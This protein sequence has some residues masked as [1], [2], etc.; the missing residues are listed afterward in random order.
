[1]HGRLLKMR[2]K[3]GHA[4]RSV[5]M[6]DGDICRKVRMIKFWEKSTSGKRYIRN[7][8]PTHL[9]AEANIKCLEH[10]TSPYCSFNSMLIDTTRLVR[11]TS[12]NKGQKCQQVRSWI[13]QLQLALVR[14]EQMQKTVRIKDEEV[15]FHFF[16]D[17]E[18]STW[19]Y[20][21]KHT[22]PLR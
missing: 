14:T 21:K 13:R 4:A 7:K 17:M 12:T 6:L 11:H 9:W 15:C 5:P 19:H 16:V 20:S 8:I 22:S 2:F 10:V 1:M 3:L 18:S